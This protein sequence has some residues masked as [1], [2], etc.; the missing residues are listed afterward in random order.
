MA[1][2][3][4]C[5]HS[6]VCRHNWQDWELEARGIKNRMDEACSDFKD[7]SL[8]IELPCK[9]GDTVY[10]H[11]NQ[12]IK[13]YT[14]REICYSDCGFTLILS[15]END[16]YF[17]GKPDDYYLTRAEAEQNLKELTKDE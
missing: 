6:G 10:E 9:V 4:D 15:D 16:I 12:M 14:V 3:K 2:C 13:S 1:S 7:K 11:H 8:I 17:E 5:L